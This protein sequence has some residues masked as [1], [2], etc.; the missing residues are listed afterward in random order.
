MVVQTRTR[1]GIMRPTRVLR[2]MVART[3]SS[4]SRWLTRGLVVA[5]ALAA[6]AATAQATPRRS[7]T[8]A[9]AAL[10]SGHTVAQL[11]QITEDTVVGVGMLADEGFIYMVFSSAAVHA[12]I[13]TLYPYTTLYD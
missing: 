8:T 6:V 4:F 1:G 13:A 9:L 12:A 5:L 10:P 2:A 7:T 3:P 11:N